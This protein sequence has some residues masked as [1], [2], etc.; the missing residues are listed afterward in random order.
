MNWV[1]KQIEPERA[2]RAEPVAELCRSWLAA[3][4]QVIRP[5]IATDSAS[6][7]I[8]F[9]QSIALPSPE[10]EPHCQREHSMAQH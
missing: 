4:R 5:A 1:N 6:V 9:E 7:A 2:V 10:P 3:S 8:G